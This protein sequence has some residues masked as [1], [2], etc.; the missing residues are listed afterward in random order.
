MF[1]NYPDTFNINLIKAIHLPYFFEL[2]AGSPARF[3]Y[4]QFLILAGVIY[5]VVYFFVAWE[6]GALTRFPLHYFFQ[7]INKRTAVDSCHAALLNTIHN[8]CQLNL[9]KTRVQFRKREL[10][11]MYVAYSLSVDFF[12]G[13]AVIIN[14]FILIQLLYLVTVV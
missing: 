4:V 2:T 13:N 10:I 1:I 12:E 8:L 11:I 9:K 7:L 6:P 3:V 5:C 14:R